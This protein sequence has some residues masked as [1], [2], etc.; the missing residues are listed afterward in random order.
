MAEFNTTKIE[1]NTPG[2]TYATPKAM[3]GK[4][5]NLGAAAKVLSQ[6]IKG[7]VLL[8]KSMTLTEAQQLAEE[9]A[10]AY[11]DGSISNQQMLLNKK[12]ETEQNLANA[13]LNDKPQYQTELDDINTQLLKAKEQGLISPSEFKMRVMQKTS[14]LANENPAYGN[15]IAAK[16]S[17]VFG[18]TGVND[19]LT[20]DQSF[21]KAQQAAQDERMKQIDTVLIKNGFPTAGIS[22]EK[23][24]AQYQAITEITQTVNTLKL[25]SDSNEV[26]DAYEFEADINA[27]GGL[28]KLGGDIMDQYY[29]KANL[30]A[31]DPLKTDKE[32]MDEHIQ[33]V[34]EARKILLTTVARLPEKQ[35][36][37]D[38]LSNTTTVLDKLEGDLEKVL[39]GTFEKNHFGNQAA[40][41]KSVAELRERAA[42]RAPETIDSLTKILGALSG[43]LENK[44]FNKDGIALKL[45]DSYS[46]SLLD[47]IDSNGKTSNPR[48]SYND[49]YLQDNLTGNLPTLNKQSLEL[50]DSGENLGP[51]GTMYNDILLQNELITNP[52]SRLTDLDQRLPILAST[53]D[54]K[55]FENLLTTNPDFSKMAGKSINFYR[56][57]ILQEAA[58]FK[59]IQGKL[60]VNKKTGMIRSSDLNDSLGSIPSRLNVLIKFESKLFGKDPGEHAEEVINSLFNTSN[61]AID[62]QIINF[63]DLT[64]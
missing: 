60:L 33:L 57:G 38:Y 35:K 63:E 27:K 47:A 31:N 30:I 34:T 56:N 32:K 52:D 13:S 28:Y 10:Q 39:D 17:Q 6:G 16:V 20:M 23:K 5:S 37:K 26:V 43:L 19:L 42:G 2:L 15:E 49:N 4:Y 55:I 51:L 46:K 25:L 29:E 14:Q 21:I 7:A 54:T 11:K 64:D 44:R 18:Y 50:L 40:I 59:D 45:L 24:F 3:S 58:T 36:Y 41:A 48:Y 1:Q 12:L 53:I 9:E 62:S 8:D 61:E 22:S